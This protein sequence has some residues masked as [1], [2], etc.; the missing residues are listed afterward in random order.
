MEDVSFW[1]GNDRQVTKV[2][3]ALSDGTRQQIL[4]Q[5]QVLTP[6]EEPITGHFDGADE[7]YHEEELEEYQ[8]EA[9]AVLIN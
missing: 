1:S 5:S 8:V 3:K 7:F 6:G 4:R 2:F 9:N